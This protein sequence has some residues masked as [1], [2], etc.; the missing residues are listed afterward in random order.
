MDAIIKSLN[1]DVTYFLAQMVMF[2]VLAVVMR[3]LYWKP[4]LSHIAG[5][6][7]KIKDAYK[8]VEHTRGEMEE[9][10]ANYQARI[11]SIEAEARTRIQS[12][13]KA[14][15]AEREQIVAVA[16]T[17]AEATVKEGTESLEREK[18]EAVASLGRWMTD[19]AQN[20]VTKSVG[21]STDSSNIRRSIEDRILG[22]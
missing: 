17:Q 14:A 1:F 5:R 18:R 21:K 3:S 20:A 12:T 2:I 16:R 13:L 11:T 6:D 22:A 4:M 19:L 7:Q 15:Q 9:L 8:S 10:R